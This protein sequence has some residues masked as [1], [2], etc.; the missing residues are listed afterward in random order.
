MTI[1]TFRGLIADGV[2][3][4]IVLHTNDGSTGY[5]I[6]KF[7]VISK[8]PGAAHSEA[9]VKI[10]KILQTTID[11]LI[12]FSDQTLLGAAMWQKSDSV[13]YGGT[14]TIIFD[15]EIFNQDIY[16]TLDHASGHTDPV[17]YYIELE[18]VKL[19]LSE[20]TVATLK[21]IRNNT[22]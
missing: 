15:Q 3:D 8:S 11:A 14:E 10:Y 18:Q 9:V 6:V 22:G 21:D 2:Q 13:T 17:N 19:D 7:Q 12:D 5:R 20:N 4:T 16:V 1:K